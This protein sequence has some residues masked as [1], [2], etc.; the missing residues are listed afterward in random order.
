MLAL[1][2]AEGYQPVRQIRMITEMPVQAVR[3]TSVLVE[4]VVLALAECLK[5]ADVDLRID[6][7][8]KEEFQQ[9]LNADR[10]WVSWFGEP[11]SEHHTPFISN[12]I[13]VAVSSP[14]CP[15]G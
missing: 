5:V 11:L 6:L 7:S 10:A 12:R 15:T 13:N 2:V 1:P 9:E 3:D 14:G 4:E 8:T